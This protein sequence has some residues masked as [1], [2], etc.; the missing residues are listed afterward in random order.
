MYSTRL[1]RTVAVA[2]LL[3]TIVRG[4]ETLEPIRQALADGKYSVAL[5]QLEE[6]LTAAPED[7][8]LHTL[9]A[10]ALAG[11]GDNAAAVSHYEIVA[12][13]EPRSAKPHLAMG[14]LAVR[15]G[16]LQEA[17]RRFQ[18][19]RALQPENAAIHHNIALVLSRR[20]EL[21]EALLA[22][23]R[24]SELAPN[25]ASIRYGLGSTLVKL[26]KRRE[27]I[28]ELRRSITVDASFS[29]AW[30]RLG[31]VL[32]QQGETEEATHAMARFRQLKAKEHF[33][34]AEAHWRSGDERRAEREYQRAL[35]GHP[36]LVDAH[37]RL[38][39]LYVRRGDLP[40]ALKHAR[41][42]VRLAPTAPQYAALGR[43]FYHAGNY[44]EALRW[45]ERAIAEQPSADLWK[46][47][48]ARIET[49]RSEAARQKGVRPRPGGGQRV[50]ER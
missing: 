27:A 28:V 20:G 8:V 36:L 10:E 6:R 45:T 42:A 1:L 17:L 5:E 29:S 41:Q 37:A 9:M 46:Q 23:R 16:R 39:S 44:R 40:Q 19:A 13:L 14:L 43:V 38:R 18:D 21:A 50:P 25:E 15:T 30:Y 7:P 32:A 33:I 47:Q 49:A 11:A 31:I 3:P 2:L 22:F 12:S 24:A 48:K 35:D 34:R 4:D 26:G